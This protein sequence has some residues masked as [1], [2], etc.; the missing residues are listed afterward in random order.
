MK[1]T[2]ASRSNI[3]EIDRPALDLCQIALGRKAMT[4]KHLSSEAHP[5]AT[6]LTHYI[7]FFLTVRLVFEGFLC[8][9]AT[10]WKEGLKKS[11][12]L[13]SFLD[14]STETKI[15]AVGSI[16]CDPANCGQ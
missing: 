8:S 15:T 6:L 3:N 2:C 14:K 11:V 7:L 10:G 13:R 9:T 1:V 5:S 4:Q 16:G 12:N